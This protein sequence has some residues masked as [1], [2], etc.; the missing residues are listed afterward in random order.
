MVKSRERLPIILGSMG[1]PIWPHKARLASQ[2]R[3]TLEIE[4]RLGFGLESGCV[5][6]SEAEAGGPRCL[7]LLS[8]W[9]KAQP[10]GMN[11][12]IRQKFDFPLNLLPLS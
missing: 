11:R 1:N 2:C 10:R 8:R 4:P 3:G 12:R 6:M 5:M 9:A 7:H